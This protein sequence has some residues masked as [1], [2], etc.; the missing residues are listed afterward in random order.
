MSCEEIILLCEILFSVALYLARAVHKCELGLLYTQ[1]LTNGDQQ[2]V[3]M[4]L[5]FV[6]VH[7]F[8]AR[9]AWR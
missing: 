5:Y 7:V 9:C 3:T 4:A 8:S 2:K 6:H 1:Q